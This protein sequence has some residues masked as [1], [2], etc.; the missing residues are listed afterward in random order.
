MQTAIIAVG[1][2]LL[3]LEPTKKPIVGTYRENVYPKAIASGIILLL[4]ALTPVILNAMGA[5]SYDNMV[6]LISILTTIAG[7]GVLVRLSYPFTK[8]RVVVFILVL[9][10]VAFLALALPKSYLG[11]MPT[12]S[13]DIMDG[14]FAH[15]FFQPWNSP[16]YNKIVSEPSAWLTILIYTVISYPQVLLVEI[17]FRNVGTMLGKKLHD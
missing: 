3:S 9:V 5:L 7:I 17:L 12:S 11:G 14:T 2:F 1:G 8:Y 6:A 16:V 15:E 4:G 10:A 13:I